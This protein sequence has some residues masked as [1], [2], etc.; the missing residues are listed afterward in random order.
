MFKLFYSNGSLIFLKQTSFAKYIALILGWP[1]TSA[2]GPDEAAANPAAV[3]SLSFFKSVPLTRWRLLFEF[4][5]CFK[6]IK[7]F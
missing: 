2:S 5:K 7:Q 6:E 3:A 4:L 1:S